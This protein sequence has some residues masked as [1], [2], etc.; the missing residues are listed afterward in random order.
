MSLLLNN[1]LSDTSNVNA[2]G[3]HL[4]DLSMPSTNMNRMLTAARLL[5][6]H[7]G[8]KKLIKAARARVS[9][10]EMVR[11][12]LDEG[13]DAS[14]A[15]VN[16]MEYAFAHYAKVV[17]HLDMAEADGI[18]AVRELR[19]VSAFNY[20]QRLIDEA[21]ESMKHTARSYARRMA[22]AGLA[23]AKS[24]TAYNSRMVKAEGL[25]EYRKAKT[26]LHRT[27]ISA[28]SVRNYPGLPRVTKSQIIQHLIAKRVAKAI[29]KME[30]MCVF[31]LQIIEL[32]RPKRIADTFDF[33]LQ[34]DII[35]FR[36]E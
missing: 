13:G 14:M 34:P 24:Y 28:G 21:Y 1:K 18:D 16:Y 4:R 27:T 26:N 33:L 7:I 31:G 19:P 6:L 22:K 23:D 12:Y 11:R 9:T 3:D 17:E 5:E 32:A 2:L 15:R 36:R 20:N 29:K 25:N 30:D 35:N 10:K 8:T